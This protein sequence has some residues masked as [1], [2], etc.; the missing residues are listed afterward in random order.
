[1]PAQYPAQITTQLVNKIDLTDIVYARDVNDAYD[2]IKA[3]QATVGVTPTATGGWGTGTF[4]TP[5]SFPTVA[6]RIK[7]LENLGVSL[8]NT[9]IRNTG[10]GVITASGATVVPLTVRGAAS[11]T[12]NLFE[13]RN[14]SGTILGRVSSA[15]S[16]V[17]N[18]DGGN[19]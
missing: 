6:A 17:I 3:I 7:N 1:M 16:F 18:I 15:G 9:A 11:Q 14:S 2:E 12:G 10:G 4:S 19:A 5:D 13:V 8:N